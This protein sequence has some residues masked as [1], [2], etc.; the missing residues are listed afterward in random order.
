M[1]LKIK[2]FGVLAEVT[3]CK[4]ETLE[5]P[6]RSLSEL[7]DLLV[8]KYPDLQTR[9]FQ[10]AQNQKLVSEETMVTHH[11]IALLPPFSGG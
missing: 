5:F 8:G 9:D 3:A 6:N 1:K 2:Y 10:F 4:E 7:K 11:E